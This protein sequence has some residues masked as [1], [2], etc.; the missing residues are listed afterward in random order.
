MKVNCVPVLPDIPVYKEMFNEDY[1]YPEI[2]LK[3]PYLNY[4][5]NREKIHEKVWNSVE[6]Y[7]S[8]DIQSELKRIHDTYYDS[9]HLKQLLCSLSR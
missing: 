1:L 3:P 9:K 5:R 8:Y 2:V 6:N 7:V 4:I